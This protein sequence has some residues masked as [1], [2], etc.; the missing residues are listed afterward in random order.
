MGVCLS[1]TTVLGTSGEATSL[2]LSERKQLAVKWISACSHHSR[3]VL[4]VVLQLA[5]RWAFYQLVKL[6][7]ISCTLSV[8]CGL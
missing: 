7:L 5:V 3:Y 8:H 4:Q 2:T 1:V 6:L